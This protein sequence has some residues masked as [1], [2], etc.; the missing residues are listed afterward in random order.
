MV[1]CDIGESF[2]AALAIVSARSLP[3][4]PLW[5]GIHNDLHLGVCVGGEDRIHVPRGWS[6]LMLLLLTSISIPL[7]VSTTKRGSWYIFTYKLLLGLYYS[8]M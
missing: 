6:L 2:T 7:H 5:P 4:K 1:I 8:V 3:M